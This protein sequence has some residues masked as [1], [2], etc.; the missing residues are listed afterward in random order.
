MKS[1]ILVIL[2]IF[3][4][5]ELYAQNK[6]ELSALSSDT[7]KIQTDQKP[8][9]KKFDKSK[10][11]YGGYV[12]L[13]FGKYTVI[14]AEPLA[15]YKLTPKLSLGV[16]LSYEYVKDKRYDEDYSTSNYGYSIFSRFR[17]TPGFYA[18][19]EYSHRS[20]ELFYLNGESERKWVPFLY[21]GG[22]ISQPVSKNTWFNAQVLFD[23]LQNENSPYNDWEPYFSVGFGVGF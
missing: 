3:L 12:N 14:G 19:A 1:S 21:L 11:Y 20:Y 9:K 4:S 6:E 8:E 10:M 15:A 5:L 18:H 2:I 13:S 16:K 22:G 23:V 7:T 17:I